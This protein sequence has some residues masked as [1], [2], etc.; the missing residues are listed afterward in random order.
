MSDKIQQ[1]T[2]ERQ[3][4]TKNTVFSR[5]LSQDLLYEFKKGMKTFWRNGTFAARNE[6]LCSGGFGG[7]SSLKHENIFTK[8]NINHHGVIM[9]RFILQ[10]F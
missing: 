9:R 6:S 4:S 8:I 7:H 2:F 10:I 3:L 5:T 1:N